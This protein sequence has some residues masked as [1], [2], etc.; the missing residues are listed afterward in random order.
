MVE[1]NVQI[2]A[3][4]KLILV[5]SSHFLVR[6]SGSEDELELLKSFYYEFLC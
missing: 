3:G 2:V 4:C 6:A 5:G 1:L